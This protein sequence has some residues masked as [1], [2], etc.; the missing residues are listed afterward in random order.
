MNG[1][2]C[3]RKVRSWKFVD[4]PRE[5]VVCVRAAKEREKKKQTFVYIL[6]EGVK[7]AAPC[8]APRVSLY[9]SEERAFVL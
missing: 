3:G 2:F 1:L 6:L 8:Y 5:Y 9:D 7:D 4:V